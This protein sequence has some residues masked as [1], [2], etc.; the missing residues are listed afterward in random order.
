MDFEHLEDLLFGLPILQREILILLAQLSSSKEIGLALLA[1]IVGLF[2]LLDD[3]LE[4]FLGQLEALL[5]EVG[6]DQIYYGL[7]TLLLVYIH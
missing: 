7:S 6:P 2:E 4:V 5:R 1:G 3:Q